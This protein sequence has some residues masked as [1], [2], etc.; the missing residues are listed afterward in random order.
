MVQQVLL[1]DGNSAAARRED[2]RC[3]GT[4]PRSDLQPTAAQTES[5]CPFYLSPPADRVSACNFF[6]FHKENI[7][8]QDK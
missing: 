6:I 5:V 8:V 1:S 7:P 2:Y 4:R 3:S